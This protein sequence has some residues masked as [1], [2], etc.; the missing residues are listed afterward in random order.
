MFL[1]LLLRPKRDMNYLR[2]L[3]PKSP[4]S[5]R[6]L[7]IASLKS[8]MLFFLFMYMF[9]S[10]LRRPKRDMNYLRYLSPLMAVAGKALNIN[11]LSFLYSAF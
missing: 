5:E 11:T 8:L 9:L 2:Y 4:F 10:L 1:S 7:A 6:G 3:S